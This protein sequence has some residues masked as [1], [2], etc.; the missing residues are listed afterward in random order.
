VA[1]A[2]R[3]KPATKTLPERLPDR[4]T[5]AGRNLELSIDMTTVRLGLSTFLTSAALARPCPA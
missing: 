1:H 2:R 3:K 4:S 5:S